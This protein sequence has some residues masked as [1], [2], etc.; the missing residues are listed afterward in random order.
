M[1]DAYSRCVSVLNAS[2]KPTEVSVQVS[3]HITRCFGV[4][5]QFQACRDKMVEMPQMIL[6]LCRILYFKVIS[7]HMPLLER[8][9]CITLMKHLNILQH[10][11]RL[12]SVAT[13]C[14]SSLAVDSILQMQLLKGG[15]LWHLILFMF[16]YDFTLEEGGVERNEEANQQVVIQNN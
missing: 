16:N 12:C 13:E 2:S 8:L 1:L 5:A 14:V 3:S 15:A 11:T 4:A 10:L 6:D 7:I 9:T